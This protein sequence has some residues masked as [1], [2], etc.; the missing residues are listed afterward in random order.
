MSHARLPP[1]GSSRWFD[2]PGSVKLIDALEI[3][4]TTS[5]PAAQGTLAHEICELS[6]KQ[7]VDPS[8][9]LGRKSTVDGFDFKVDKE[10]VE[11]CREYVDY[12]NDNTDNTFGQNIEF[13]LEVPCP[14]SSYGVP[15]LDG[16]TS[17]CVIVNHDELILEIVDYKHGRGVVEVEANKQLMQ[18]GLGALINHV[19]T[20]EFDDV[21]VSDYRVILT[22]VQP[23]AYH[24]D[25]PIRS[26]EISAQELIDWGN[27]VLKPA[28]ELCN[29]DD[30]PITPSEDACRWC[31]V[32]TCKARYD[33][34]MDVTG[35]DN[36]TNDKLMDVQ[37]IKNILRYSGMIR[38]FLDDVEK[39]VIE[40]INSGSSDYAGDY[41]LVESRPR[42][43]LDDNA[44]DELF[45]PLLDYLDHSDLYESKP[46]GVTAIEKSV[47]AKL[48][49]DGVKGFNKRAKE[50]MGEVTFKP[51]GEP[52]LVEDSDPR[53]PISCGIGD[54][55]DDVL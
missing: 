11:A 35:A 14:L 37:E 9:F 47:A 32:K 44:F 10:M 22:I 33:A 48:K 20:D 39:H 19:Y 7:G 26:W 21:S 27:N 34:T 42:R 45:S 15:G 28:A 5:Y 13:M 51:K 53:D 38:Q 41:K 31:P 25:G 24:A 12:I 1:S 2:C 52:I 17:D 18:Y 43:R 3:Q 29:S 6:I 36:I 30:A 8:E 50:I 4:D 54:E 40:E 49:A 23:R 16:G 46:K 55:F